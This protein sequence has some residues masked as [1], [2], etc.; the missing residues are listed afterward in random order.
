M[1]EHADAVRT[2]HEA[3]RG[4]RELGERVEE[5]LDA[6]DREV[7]SVLATDWRGSGA[8]G[9]DTHWTTLR[10]AVQEALPAF[11]LAATDLESAAEAVRSTAGGDTGSDGALYGASG[12][13]AGQE[14]GGV[15]VTSAADA[16]HSARSDVSTS[17]LN[18]LVSAQLEKGLSYGGSTPEGGPTHESGGEAVSDVRLASSSSSPL[19]S[20][21]G[22]TTSEG[23]ST[24]EQTSGGTPP[25]AMR[26]DSVVTTLLALAATISTVF[27]RGVGRG[28]GGGVGALPLP[29]LSPEISTSPPIDRVLD[30]SLG[31]VHPEHTERDKHSEDTRDTRDT[32]DTDDTETEEAGVGDA[33][34]DAESDTSGSAVE[35]G[36]FG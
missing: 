8:E 2:L 28:P 5:T 26:T 4:W 6:L 14:T 30:E 15:G 1:N 21:L 20:S 13:L 25:V 10:R 27:E 12:D 11:E 32:D 16:T 35:R 36:A 29:N 22:A 3:A 7:R 24:D 19:E 34:R 18:A 33:R 9:F 31:S 17:E 23:R